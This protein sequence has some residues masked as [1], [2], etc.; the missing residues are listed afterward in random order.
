MQRRAGRRLISCSAALLVA[1]ACASSPEPS[2]APPAPAP[3]PV[4][5]PEP[6]VCRRITEIEV[7]KGE[8]R[9]LARCE[10]GAVVEL[11]VALGREPQGP[12]RRAGDWRTPEGR[13]RISGEPQPSRFHLFIPIDYPSV[14]DAEAARAE[15]RLPEGA[16]R[17]ILAAHAGGEPPPGNTPLGGQL[18]FHGEGE[19][20]RG[21]SADL[22]WTYGCVALSDGDVEFLAERVE[23]GTPVVI[24]P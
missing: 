10:G 16:Y 4:R 3:L 21:D 22:D 19:R 24:G 18:G 12:K 20:W 6:R 1:S 23:I 15:A 5:E 7:E 9:L 11:P 17:R 8:R 2:P 14:A 13:Y